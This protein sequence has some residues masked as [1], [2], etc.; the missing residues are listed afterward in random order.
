MINPTLRR[1]DALTIRITN[2][3]HRH[4]GGGRTLRC[5]RGNADPEFT[6]RPR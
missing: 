6:A 3:W 2:P 4:P 1:H 5:Y